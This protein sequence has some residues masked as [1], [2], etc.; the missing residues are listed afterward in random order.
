MIIGTYFA[1]NKLL[2]EKFLCELGEVIGTAFGTSLF[3]LSPLISV[4]LKC[5]AQTWLL[6]L[7]LHSSIFKMFFQI[8]FVSSFDGNLNIGT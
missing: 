7:I 1:L 4:S 8:C 5:L 6:F 2:A 3:I